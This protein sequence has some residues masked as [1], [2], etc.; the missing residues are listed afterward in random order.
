VE[1]VWQK[2]GNLWRE[3]EKTNNGWL[4]AQANGRVC[5]TDSV[6]DLE[7]RG[8]FQ[9]CLGR[10]IPDL[11]EAFRQTEH[12]IPYVTTSGG[13]QGYIKCEPISAYAQWLDD[14]QL[15]PVACQVWPYTTPR[16]QS[17][18]LTRGIWVLSPFLTNSFFQIKCRQDSLEIL[19]GDE[20][21]GKW[22]DWKWN[23]REKL[24]ANL[25]PSSGEYLLIKRA[26]VEQ[27][28]ESEKCKFCWICKL[29]MYYREHSYQEYKTH[30][31]IK[32]YGSS[33]I[34]VG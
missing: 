9:R 30:S 10:K 22:L 7:I 4:I 23:F 16:W 8:V 2:A 5:Q 19:D 26:K 34:I 21:V 29:T 18:R 25:T 13:V 15:L 1:D 3:N 6:Y 31:W 14:W 28:E 32:E 11:E 20:V 12:T 33:S 27:F 17:W 24:T